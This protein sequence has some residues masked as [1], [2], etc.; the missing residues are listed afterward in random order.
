LQQIAPTHPGLPFFEAELKRRQAEAAA[1]KSERSRPQV[2]S[3]SGPASPTRKPA[4]RGTTF[5]GTTLEDTSTG[6]H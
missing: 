5:S 6:N 2:V 1:A 4:S 3:P